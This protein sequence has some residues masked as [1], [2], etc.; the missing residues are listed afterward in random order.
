MFGVLWA[1]TGIDQTYPDDYKPAR[2]D[3]E[4]GKDEFKDWIPPTLPQDQL[5]WEVLD[6][7]VKLAGDVPVLVINEPIL[8][9][10]GENSDIRYNFFYPRWAYDQYRQA[11]F[12]KAED[13]KWAFIDLWNVVPGDEFTNSALHLTPEGMDI[14]YN[15]LKPSLM[16]FIQP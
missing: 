10:E 15:A 8:I 9:S 14:F 7:G 6:A 4:P 5:S 13:A 12:T 3:F 1:A 16:K 11:L 2:R